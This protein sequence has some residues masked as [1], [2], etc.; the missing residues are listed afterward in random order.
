[1]GDL[2]RRTPADVSKPIV[3][4]TLDPVPCDGYSQLAIYMVR[5]IEPPNS[6]SMPGE[7]IGIASLRQAFKLPDIRYGFV[8]EAWG[9]GYATEV[10]K[11]LLRCVTERY[12]GEEV[13][14]IYAQR[15]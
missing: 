9:K 11:E 5:S 7:I 3:P 4:W 1:M 6:I 2:G 10:G 15:T 12:G 8:P 14:C 13:N